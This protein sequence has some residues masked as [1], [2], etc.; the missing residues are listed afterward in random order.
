MPYSAFLLSSW[1]SCSEELGLSTSILLGPGEHGSSDKPLAQITLVA[2]GSWSV[3][4][5]L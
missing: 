5:G 1:L 4:E 2:A 3:S